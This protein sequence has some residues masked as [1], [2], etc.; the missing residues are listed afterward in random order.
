MP[1]SNDKDFKLG[2]YPIL[3]YLDNSRYCRY[4]GRYRHLYRLR[5]GAIGSDE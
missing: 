2:H 4:G 1:R 5:W 3:H